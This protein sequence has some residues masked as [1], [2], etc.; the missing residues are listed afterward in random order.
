MNEAVE[1]LLSCALN[2][3]A[4]LNNIVTKR[5]QYNEGLVII[6]VLWFAN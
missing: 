3:M 5:L 2:E 4:I 6:V 1:A